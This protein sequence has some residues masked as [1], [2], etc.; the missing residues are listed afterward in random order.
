MAKPWEY[1]DYF[2][3]TPYTIVLGRNDKTLQAV[4][5]DKCAKQCLQETDFICRSFD[6]QWMLTDL[7][8]MSLNEG[9]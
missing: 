7:S 2:Y 8:Y 9:S 5:A 4:S 1:V 3:P 6:Y